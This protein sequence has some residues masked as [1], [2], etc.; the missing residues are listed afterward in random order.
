A[1]LQSLD[2]WDTYL[3][4]QSGLPGPRSNLELLQVVADLGDESRF[5]RYLAFDAAHKPI[6]SPYEYLSLCGV[7]GQGKLLAEGKKRP[8][9]RLRALASDPRWRIREGAAMALQRWG[10][11]DMEALLAAMKKWS[12]GNP[13]E[14]RAAA[15]AL[16]EPRLLKDKKQVRQVL[17]IL[18][19][20]TASMLKARD[21]QRDE[22][23][24]LKKGMGYC[25][26]VAVAASPEDGKRAMEKW[27]TREDKDIR[28][29]MA[30][31]LKKNRLTKMDA[32]WVQECQAR[33]AR[34]P[35]ASNSG[36]ET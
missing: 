26:S 17:A 34:S 1:M 31:N 2:D 29:V 33:L 5:D 32:A 10:D 18:G 12:T 27:L 36:D 24:A 4:Q 6:N 9:K 28:W 14:Q 30:E 25:W 8:L 3:M 20:I 13:L 23:Q 7:V 19:V 15:A 22:F 16:C 11:A 35:D 21:R